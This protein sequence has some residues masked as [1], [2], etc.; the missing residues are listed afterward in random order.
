MYET[1]RK[2]IDALGGYRIVAERLR[3]SAT[4]LHSH[5]SSGELPSK[6]YGAFLALAAEAAIEP[7]SRDIFSFEDLPPPKERDVA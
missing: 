3:M 6:W 5:M 4:T 2:F 1:A 7:P